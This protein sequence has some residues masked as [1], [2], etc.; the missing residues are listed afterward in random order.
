MKLIKPQVQFLQRIY[1]LKGTVS[2]IAERAESWVK[3]DGEAVP[4]CQRLMRSPLAQRVVRDL[5]YWSWDA[6]QML[7][8]YT[9]DAEPSA[10]QILEDLSER[11]FKEPS[12]SG[13]ADSCASEFQALNLN[14][15][16]RAARTLAEIIDNVFGRVLF[17]PPLSLSPSPSQLRHGCDD[18]TQYLRLLDGKLEE[19]LYW[20]G[21]ILE[22]LGNMMALNGEVAASE[23]DMEP[24]ICLD[25]FR[26]RR[27]ESVH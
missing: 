15:L 10:F 26:I 21:E 11:S 25:Q 13:D 6:A 22:D 23:R 2:S 17:E 9:V 5:V 16:N 4:Y 19:K 24:S 7:R 27:Q 18:I 8:E 14:E 20:L 12:G 1:L 3:V